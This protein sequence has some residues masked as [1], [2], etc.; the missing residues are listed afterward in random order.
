[1]AFLML[2]A[3]CPW[4]VPAD[5]DAPDV[6]NVV[7]GE[8][9][10]T[11]ADA[12][13]PTY[14]LVFD[15][16]DP[17]PPAGTGSPL[18]FA[19]VPADA[20]TGPDAGVQAAPYAVTRI[21]DGDWLLT[22]LLDADGDFQP[23]LSTNAGATCGDW[24]GGHL[25]DLA[26]DTLAPVH[27]EGGV[28]LDDVT[29][30]VGAELTTERPAFTLE[31]PSVSQLE[32]GTQLVSLAS[33]GIH[34]ALVD[35]ADPG[36]GAC[37]TSF[38]FYAPD[39]DADGQPDPHPNPALAAAGAYD[40]WPRVYLQYLGEDVAPG[41]SWSAE[42]VVYPG[43]LLSGEIALGVPTPVTTLDLVW[44]PAAI[45]TDPDGVE[46]IVTAPSL[47]TG[48]WSVT[49]VSITGQTWTVPN[50]VAAFPSTSPDF[51]PSTQGAALL[52]E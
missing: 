49:V 14:V 2:L 19:S 43:P 16:E 29:L 50:E 39:A 42:M 7:S 11:G 12:A 18:T 4:S 41:E 15:A 26:S 9:V 8:V 28:A 6:L 21:P 32:P 33:T 36:S 34:S 46:T 23:L 25:A 44:V 30:V 38:L 37:A 47:P 24:I 51:D 48:A 20:F 1:M 10:V 40:V 17:P 22:A 5:P 13:A 52:V 35:F 45:H 31:T 3:G 27:V